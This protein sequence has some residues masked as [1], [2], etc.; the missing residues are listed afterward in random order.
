MRI[1]VLH[2]LL[3]RVDSITKTI[4]KRF[5]V[6]NSRVQTVH[7]CWDNVAVTSEEN[8]IT[9]IGWYDKEERK[10]FGTFTFL[11]HFTA[12][13]GVSSFKEPIDKVSESVLFYLSNPDERET[14]PS[15]EEEITF[16]K[17]TFEFNA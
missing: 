3:K 10:D 6:R 13:Y 14:L 1:S 5:F 8:K 15:W 16:G 7:L 4:C 11:E 17:E 9:I 12:S 2:R